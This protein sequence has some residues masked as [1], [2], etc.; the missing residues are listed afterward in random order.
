MRGAVVILFGSGARGTV[1]SPVGLARVV[2]FCSR[3]DVAQ[4]VADGERASQRGALLCRG[5]VGSELSALGGLFKVGV[6][7]FVGRPVRAAVGV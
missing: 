6:I 7:R 4:L 5:E 1:G 3:E 2:E